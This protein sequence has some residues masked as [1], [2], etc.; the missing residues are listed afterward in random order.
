MYRTFLRHSIVFSIVL[1]ICACVPVTSAPTSLHAT[2][3]PP[4][5]TATKTNTPIPTSTATASTT[6][7]PALPQSMWKLYARL[8]SSNYQIKEDS[9]GNFDVQDANGNLVEGLKVFED[10]TVQLILGG[11]ELWVAFQSIHVHKGNLVVGLWDYDEKSKTWGETHSQTAQEVIDGLEDYHNLV[12]IQGHEKESLMVATIFTAR[13]LAMMSTTGYRPESEYEN[14]TVTTM[15]GKVIENYNKPARSWKIL[16][17]HANNSG[18]YYLKPNLKDSE[19]VANDGSS[20][21]YARPIQ[22]ALYG[23]SFAVNIIN[24]DS[25]LSTILTHFTLLAKEQN[26]LRYFSA[27]INNKDLP[28]VTLP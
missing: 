7:T 25:E 23:G 28:M 26:G 5:S 9:S 1:T 6:A 3:I 14:I 27:L 17:S 16:L 4:A 10:E 13:D 22:L 21:A 15:N 20:D 8:S 18:L 2:N 11:K 19:V 24:Q 12:I